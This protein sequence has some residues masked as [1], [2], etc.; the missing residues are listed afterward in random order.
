MITRLK[1]RRVFTHTPGEY[2]DVFD[3]SNYQTLL[4]T[5]VTVEKETLPHKYFSD[6]CDIAFGGSTDGFQVFN[7][8]L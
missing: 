1:Y 2:N 4:Q 5:N 6:P 8:S 7:L 3:G